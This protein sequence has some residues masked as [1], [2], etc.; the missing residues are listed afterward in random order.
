MGAKG[1]Y[2]GNHIPGKP[3]IVI[4]K[5]RDKFCLDQRQP[6]IPGD[7]RSAASGTDVRHA[8]AGRHIAAFEVWSIV[9]NNDPA[10]RRF[11]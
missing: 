7:R 3:A 5:K 1:R 2:L 4:V 8:E 9:D 6:G 10:R 11:Y